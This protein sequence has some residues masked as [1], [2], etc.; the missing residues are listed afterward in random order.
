MNLRF[1]NFP[2]YFHFPFLLL[3][4]HLLGKHSRTDLFWQSRGR[5]ELGGKGQGQ[6]IA[7]RSTIS[8]IILPIDSLS[9]TYYNHLLV[10]LQYDHL[11]GSPATLHIK[12]LHSC[13]IW[14][15]SSF[16]FKIFLV[17]I[18]FSWSI[19]YFLPSI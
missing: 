19:L 8:F 12:S 10:S 7:F 17:Y 18:L 11:S 16:V 2:L 1:K 13:S 4:Q 5:R 9:I 14:S 15:F 6:E 3:R